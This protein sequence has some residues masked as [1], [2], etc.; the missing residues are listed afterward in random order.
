[1]GEH[2]SEICQRCKVWKCKRHD[3]NYIK[4][5]KELRELHEQIAPKEEIV[6][7][8]D[9][10]YEI[11]QRIEN[12]KDKLFKMSNKAPKFKDSAYEIKDLY[13][14]MKYYDTLKELHEKKYRKVDVKVANK[15]KQKVQIWHNRILEKH[16]I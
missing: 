15:K 8:I 2:K 1:M 4:D 12:V 16:K 13:E 6:Q 14:G 5:D 3:A 10:C 7:E 9:S 11:K